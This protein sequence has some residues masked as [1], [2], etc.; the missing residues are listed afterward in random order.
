VGTPA[1]II[2]KESNE[3][4]IVL[5]KKMDGYPKNEHGVGTIKQILKA[6]YSKVYIKEIISRGY[7]RNNKE[8]IQQ[9]LNLCIRPTSCI[10]ASAIVAAD[11]GNT[12]PI[13]FQGYQQYY[14]D[15]FAYDYAFKYNIFV[16]QDKDEDGD[17]IWEMSIYPNGEED[18][19]IERKTIKDYRKEFELDDFLN[20]AR[21]R[22]SI[23]I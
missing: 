12:W 16:L 17:I 4:D 9:R 8:E 18:T 15:G 1:N 23:L 22:G 3:R 7:I 20:K 13:D 19:K 2:I 5:F 11:P 6:Y 14:K 21:G 10:E